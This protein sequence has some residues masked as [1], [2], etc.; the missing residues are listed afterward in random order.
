MNIICKENRTEY[1]LD[2]KGTPTE[3]KLLCPV[4]SNDRKKKTL[5]CLSWNNQNNLG[6]CH[7]CGAAFYLKKE[8]EK[9]F[10]YEKPVWKNKTDLPDV[11]VKWF[12]ERKIKQ[13][14]LKKLKITN[15]LE[16]MPQIGKEVNTIQ[17][18]YFRDS[19]LIN[20]KYRDNQKNFKLYKN[21]E[22][23]FYNIDATKYH[24]EI[25]IVEGEIDCLSMIQ[26]GYENTVSVPN[27]ANLS[28]NNLQYIDN[29]I[30][31]LA[32]KKIIIAVD[33]DLAGR[34][35]REDISERFGKENCEYIEFKDCKDA[36][37]CLIKYGIQGIIESCSQPKQFPLE[38]VFTIKDFEN[39][40][41]D[42][43]INGLDKGVS[44]G[45]EGFNLNIVKGYITT[46]TGVPSHGKSDWLDNICLHLKINHDW[47]G[48]FYSPENKPTQLHFS[49]MAR[50]L[51]GKHW[52]GTG[53][54]SD[55][56]KELV[57]KY[58]DKSFWFIKP[59]KDFTL[60]SILNKVRNLQ[61]RHGIDFFV[62][63]A[64]NKL[65]HRHNDKQT[66]YIGRAM[67]ELALFCEANNLHCFLVAH[68]TKMP[69][70]EN[71]KYEVPTLYNIAGS[72]NFYNKTDNGVCVYRDFDTGITRVFIQKIKFDH[73]GS[74]SYCDYNYELNSKRYF[75]IGSNPDYSN[76]ITKKEK[77][78]EIYLENPNKFIEP[79]KQFLDEVPF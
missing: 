54:I 65:E 4:C 37:E 14:I 8:K 74:D 60:Q 69:K 29:S 34:K 75:V 38:G 73:W 70:K 52:D 32:G 76:W 24:E 39:E 43:Y 23:I 26:A 10:I 59:E 44:T 31:L 58:L 40:I 5:K 78:T 55:S 33:N 28:K 56:E 47:K 63:D 7:H 11:I 51:I 46:V 77:Q 27:G 2:I 53:R 49:K 67:D 19:E 36:N 72:A 21:A 41:D 61:L 22:L 71:G 1:I 62:I 3:E 13:E 35:L 12:E 79:N 6:K 45:I 30:D 64:W 16:F 42:M 66:D 18:N 25:I 15:G 20:I 9:D 17:F 68:P 48:A 50:K 57:K